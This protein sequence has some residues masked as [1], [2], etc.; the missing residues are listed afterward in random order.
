MVHGETGKSPTGQVLCLVG[1]LRSRAP[2]FAVL[3]R[4]GIRFRKS[5]V[6][7]RAIA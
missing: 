1:H 2:S 5:L 6:Q 4:R 3:G 7:L